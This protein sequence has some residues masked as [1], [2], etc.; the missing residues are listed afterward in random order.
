MKK[1]E[2]PHD[3]GDKRSAE[4]LCREL[5]SA[6]GFDAAAELFRQMSDP[7]R[8]RIFWI[9]SHREECVINISAMLGMSS[10]AVSHHLR[11]MKDS[12]IIESRRDGKEVYYRVADGERGILLHDVIERIS[13]IACPLDRR[14]SSR[15]ETVKRVHDHLLEHLSERITIEELSKQFHINPTTLK[16]S[17]REY[18]GDSIAA[19]VNEH[20]MEHAA[21]L[22]RSEELS[23]AEVASRVGF[24]SQSRFGEAFKEKY[25]TTPA[26]FRTAKRKS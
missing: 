22:L 3:H 2:L 20:R 10:P 26:E 15:E 17:F 9:L 12:G 6:E 25:G 14:D 4:R 5:E 23:V 7:V 21:E 13:E 19:H 11:H 24:L 8:V 16:Q 18:Y 1:F